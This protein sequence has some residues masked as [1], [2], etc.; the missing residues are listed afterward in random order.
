[1]FG[2]NLAA[3]I[4]GSFLQ[5]REVH[6]QRRGACP[7]LSLPMPTGDGLLVRLLP[8]G[9]I[10]LD[11]FAALCDA[12]Q[13]HGNG[14]IEIT[15][16]GSIQVRGL[17]PD[18]APHFAPAVGAA[19]IAG[20]D[21]VPVLSNALAGL[22]PEEILDAS[23][24]ARDLRDALARESLSA[25]VSP[26]VSVII[27][28]GG[29]VSLDDIAADVR[30]RAEM[31]DGRAALRVSVGGDGASS[32]D[33]G[34]VACARSIEA[35]IGL[36]E[37][38]A[39]RGRNARAREVVA[40]EGPAPFRAALADAG[41]FSEVAP[42]ARERRQGETIGAHRLRDGSLAYG[43]G[44]AFG[45]AD[46]TSLGRLV[47]AARSAG[48]SG[49]RAAP[50]RA[51]MAIGFAQAAAPTFAA[52]AEQFGFITHADDPRRSVIACAGAPVCSAAHIAAR[53]MAPAIAVAAAPF[54]DRSFTIHVSG[55][56]KGC[57][58]PRPAALTVVGTSAGC[59]LVHDGSPRDDPNA[60]VPAHEL[61]AA[62]ER[63]ARERTTANRNV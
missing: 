52:S 56:A 27:D 28:G 25:A 12:A 33:I 21:G 58:H 5:K 42:S 6:A 26:K 61:L 10:A 59:A 3:P 20:A 51:V 18:S 9:T 63:A 53:A 47:E 8:T 60:V 17:T 39:R 29:N 16:R 15:S 46:A 14:V 37:V 48:A 62:I 1:M 4:S 40:A 43:I 45:H 49:L 34:I 30:L 22:D 23:A 35:A 24:L 19:A 32:V 41:G 44:L 50:G 7:G 55:C 38:I 54:L 11:A 31:S 13:A 57:A 2:Q 36:L